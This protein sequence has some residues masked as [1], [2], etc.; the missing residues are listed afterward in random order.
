MNT[1]LTLV[2]IVGACG[3]IVKGVQA[4]L[5]GDR[6]AALYAVPFGVSILLYLA[7]KQLTG[8]GE[9]GAFVGGAV[10]SFSLIGLERRLLKRGGR[11]RR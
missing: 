10:A 5:N 3:L 2:G 6:D 8:D 4:Y 11:A 9:M 1:I 7:V